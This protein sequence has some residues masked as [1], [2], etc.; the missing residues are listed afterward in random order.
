MAEEK[1]REKEAREAKQEQA[2]VQTQAL[3]VTKTCPGHGRW[4]PAGCHPQCAERDR[5]S[6]LDAS[7]SEKTPHRRSSHIPTSLPHRWQRWTEY[8]R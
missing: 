5:N 4:K 7:G 3:S 8:R 1:A 6:C 2:R